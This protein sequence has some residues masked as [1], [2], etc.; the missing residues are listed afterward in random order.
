MTLVVEREL[1]AM[2]D[3]SAAA[4]PVR[5]LATRSGPVVERAAWRVYYRLPAFARAT[6]RAT[7]RRLRAA[8][9]A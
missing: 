4:G 6:A 8:A 3:P 7:F 1:P 2:R 9:R 5:A